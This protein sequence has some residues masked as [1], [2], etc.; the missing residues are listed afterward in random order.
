[1]NNEPLSNFVLTADAMEKIVIGPR[2]V[3]EV[4]LSAPDQPSRLESR[5]PPPIP[6]WARVALSPLVL[7]LPLL[8]LV[9]FVL[10]VAMRGLPPRTRIAWLSFLS[11]LLIISGILTSVSAVLAVAFVPLP[12]IV[13]GSLGELDGKTNFPALPS[14]MPLSAKEVSEELKPLVAVISPAQRTWSSRSEVPS[15]GFGAGVLLEASPQ[16]YLLMTARHVLDEPRFIRGGS[17]ALGAMAS[18]TGA[19]G[20]VVA[21]HKDLDL[22]LIWLP[23]ESGSGDF[24][25]PVEAKKEIS[26]GE[27]IFVIGH[28]QGLRFTLSTGI[29]SR[30]DHDVLQIS[31][32][33]SPGNSGGPV[34][35]DRGNLVG[36]VTSMVDRN[37]SPNA[38]NL[39]F[40]VRAD[41]VLD[42]EGWNFSKEGRKRLDE[43]VTAER[44]R[45]KK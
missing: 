4:T 29:I 40:A 21:R 26:E 2:E 10:R 39:N 45:E 5:L 7:V 35:D 25:Q 12:A 3:S 19:G 30:A 23:R 41:A 44:L 38:E 18:G 24:V 31:A 42:P 34:Y 22:C 8:C 33:V 9:T 28:P 14:A 16:G 36:I 11:T 27:N 20:D 37:I 15:N 17:R 6:L 32:P 1:M 43:F 13:S